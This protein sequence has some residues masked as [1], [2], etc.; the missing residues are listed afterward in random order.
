VHEK[1][2]LEVA[3]GELEVVEEFVCAE[4]GAAGDLGVP[5]EVSVEVGARW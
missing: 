1:L 3:P 4:M 2:L 5:L